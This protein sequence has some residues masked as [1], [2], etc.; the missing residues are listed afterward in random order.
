MNLASVELVYDMEVVDEELN[1]E[2]AEEL[3]F[4]INTQHHFGILKTTL[5]EIVATTIQLLEAFAKT[6]Q[7]FRK[8]KAEVA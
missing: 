8:S 7:I 3:N 5:T 6:N 4:L 2:Q 1:I